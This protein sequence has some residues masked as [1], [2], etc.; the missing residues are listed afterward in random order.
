MKFSINFIASAIFFSMLFFEQMTAK[1]F[2]S[3]PSPLNNTISGCER[4][5]PVWPEQLFLVQHRI[6]DDDSGNST[7][8][9]YYDWKRQANLIIIN[10]DS[11]QG[12]KDADIIWDL[13]LSNHHSY[14]FNPLKKTCKTM[15][16][17]VGILKPNWLVNATCLGEVVM[18]GRRT[19][20]WT[21]EDFIDYYAD[22]VTDEPVSW[23]FHTMKARFDTIFYSP[24]KQ[25]P[26]ES[27]FEPPNYCK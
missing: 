21:K 23:Y 6:P 16:F 9:T 22:A 12:N 13:E 15:D 5:P 8:A 25:V 27:F 7:I 1:E 19:I 4:G 14:F 2:L 20:G 3:A 18:N 17:P 24:G 11:N 26:S 10:P